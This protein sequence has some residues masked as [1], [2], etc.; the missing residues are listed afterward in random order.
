LYFLIGE[1]EKRDVRSWIWSDYGWSHP[2]LFFKKMPKS[3]LQSNWWYYGTSFD[4]DQLEE[5][6]KTRVKFYY[7]LEKHGYDQVPAGSNWTIDANLEATVENLTK[8]IDKSRLLGFMQTP[9]QPTL[10]PCLKEHED[11]INQLGRAIKKY[12]R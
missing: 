10:L 8:V 5:S 11:A 6:D 9:W 2:D 4:L 7:D 12:Y 3:V 1:V